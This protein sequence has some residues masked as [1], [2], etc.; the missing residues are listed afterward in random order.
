MNRPGTGENTAYAYKP[1]DTARQSTTTAADDP[2]L[3]VAV[4]AGGVYRVSVDLYYLTS[5]TADLKIGFSAPAG[6]TLI[7]SGD[8]PPSSASGAGV[9]PNRAATALANTVTAGG[10]A[11]TQLCAR[12]VG[13]LTAAANG[14]L[15]LQ[16]AQAVSEAVDST[17]L[18]GSCMRVERI[19]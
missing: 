12:P 5:A 14:W 4:K 8:C 18:A 16:W 10:V 2:H 17:V 13:L 1:A 7:W 19:L 3:S 15:T 11:A 6:S 9:S